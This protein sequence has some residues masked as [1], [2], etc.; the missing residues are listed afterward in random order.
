MAKQTAALPSL[1]TTL[2]AI[3]LIPILAI[4]LVYFLFVKPSMRFHTFH[5]EPFL[6]DFMFRQFR[7]CKDPLALN[8]LSG[9]KEKMT[10]AF[11]YMY[12]H[13]RTKDHIFY[14]LFNLV[15]QFSDT[16]N[17]C[18]YGYDYK[19]EH[20]FE[21][22][23]PLKFSEIDFQEVGATVIVQHGTLF[24][25]TLNFDTEVLTYDLNYSSIRAHY[26][27][28][29]TDWNTNQG[30]FLP[31]YRPL[32]LFTNI[33]GKETNV[34]GEWMV[35]SPAIGDVVRGELNGQELGTGQFWFDTYTGTNYH[36]LAPY[37]W[38]YIH[39]ADWMIYLLQYGE[40]NTVTSD[41]TTSPILIKDLK[42]DTWYVSGAY[43][44]MPQPFQMLRNLQDP[45]SLD[46]KVDGHLGDNY[47]VEFKARDIE[48]TLTPVPGSIRPVFKYFYYKDE[49]INMSAQ[50]AGDRE[51]L[52]H[53]QRI[54]FDENLSDSI[55]T[56]RRDGRTETFQ[57]RTIYEGMTVV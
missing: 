28:K 34:P 18:V 19:N 26:E 29:V 43:K 4:A 54:R 3:L 50:S 36:Y 52:S 24:K 47:R 9:H 15:N 55:V 51:Y 35:D 11:W 20:P 22:I 44:K 30:S 10:L 48:I 12:Y 31:Q 13:I 46:I 56:V 53:I 38:F 14:T 39:T 23:I 5:N 16:I 33:D 1:K 45:M 21:H 25:F 17:L 42:A 27:L 41:T 57:A 40:L 2:W 37:T 7:G 32:R 6:K 49:T 8:A